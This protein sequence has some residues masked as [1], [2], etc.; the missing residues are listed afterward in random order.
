MRIIDSINLAYIAGFLGGDGSIFFQIIKRSDYKHK[1][2]IRCSVA[3]YQKTKYADILQELKKYFGSG[4]IRHRKTGISDYTIVEFAEVKKI[5]LLLKP[6]VRVKKQQLELGLS[7]LNKLESR[8]SRKDFLEICNLV[9]KFGSL[10]NSKK[11]TI[12]SNVVK[13]YFTNNSL[14]L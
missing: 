10:N 14:P 8:K 1:F 9:D 2:Q 13:D 3:F 11:R 6:F 4:Y 12:N 5:L 7:I